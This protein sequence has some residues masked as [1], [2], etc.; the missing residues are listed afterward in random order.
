MDVSGTIQVDKLQ[1]MG[2][3][4]FEEIMKVALCGDRYFIV[5]FNGSTVL[6]KHHLKDLSYTRYERT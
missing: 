5:L 1:V 4:D 6:R 3:K 2:L